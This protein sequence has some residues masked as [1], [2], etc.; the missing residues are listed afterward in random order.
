VL[1]LVQGLT[2]FLPVVFQYG[3]QGTQTEALRTFVLI[4]LVYGTVWFV[5]ILL[6]ADFMLFRRMLWSSELAKFVAIIAACALLVGFLLPGVALMVG[7]PLTGVVI[8]A[9]A[10]IFRRPIAI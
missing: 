9:V 2:T 10:R 7:F 4:S 6:L 1:G 3:L 8:I 5:P